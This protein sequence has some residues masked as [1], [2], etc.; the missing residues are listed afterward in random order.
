MIAVLD[1]AHKFSAEDRVR[2]RQAG[3]QGFVLP[4]RNPR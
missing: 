2:G 1:I 3:R 4:S